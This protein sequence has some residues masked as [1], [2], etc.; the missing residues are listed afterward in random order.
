MTGYRCFLA[1]MGKCPD[2]LSL[3]RIDNDGPYA[4]WNCRWAT[5]EDQHNNQRRTIWIDDTDGERLPMAVFCK[6][7]GVPYEYFC[8]RYRPNPSRVRRGFKAWTVEKI[9]AKAKILYPGYVSV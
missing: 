9:L 3:E 4:P 1:D 5:M 2:G 8:E 6:K 7:H